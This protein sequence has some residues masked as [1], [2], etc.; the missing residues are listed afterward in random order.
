MN[1]IRFL[2]L[3]FKGPTPQQMAA[4]LRKPHG[5]M[6]RKVGER[7]NAANRSLY[8]GAWEALDL[9][10][11]MSVLEI[12][13]GN[14]L[15][16][17]DLARRAKALRLHG[18][19]FSKDM[20]EQA[21]ERNAELI[22]S[23]VLSLAHGPSDRMPFADAS[24]DRVFCINVVYFW[25]DPGV[26]LREVRRV[27][28]PGGTFTAVLRTRASMESMPFTA[29]GFTKYEQDDWERVL[30]ANGF[31]TTGTAVLREPEI[32]FAGARFTPE[33]LVMTSV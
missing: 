20:V 23:G 25:D 11:G 2:R 4:Q 12:G 9:R 3:L 13:F 31:T 19:D 10:D 29:F 22:A 30:R 27:L 8:E 28:K 15:F 18:L 17:G 32:E 14:G 33:S 26:H 16:F 7:M 1:P 24:F 21:T 5:F 6:A